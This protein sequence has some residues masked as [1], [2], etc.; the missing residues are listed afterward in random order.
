MSKNKVEMRHGQMIKVPPVP[1]AKPNTL[2]TNSPLQAFA[3]RPDNRFGQCKP[4]HVR[5]DQ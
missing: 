5:S 1:G 4:P 2:A 3:N